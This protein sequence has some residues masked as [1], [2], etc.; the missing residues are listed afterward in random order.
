MTSVFAREYC[1]WLTFAIGVVVCVGILFIPGFLLLD[2][3]GCP[4]SLA[5]SLS[6][7]ISIL[8]CVVSGSLFG[9]IGI[10]VSWWA[11]VLPGVALGFVCLFLSKVSSSFQFQCES[12]TL[13]SKAISWKSLALFLCISLVVTFVVF[14]K[15]LD[16]PE[17][18]VQEFDNAYHLNL[19]QTFLNTGRFSTIQTALGADVPIQPLSEISYYPAAWHII[20]AL[21][22]DAVGASAAMAENI[23][24]AVFL[25]FVYPVSICAYLSVVFKTNRRVLICAAFLFMAFSAFPW[26]FLVAGPLYSNFAAMALFPA[27]MALLLVVVEMF[28]SHVAVVPG[29]V[30][31]AS[32]FSAALAQPNVL[33]TGAV[34]LAPYLYSHIARLFSGK[35]VWLACAGVALC[36]VFLWLLLRHFPILTSVVNNAWSPYVDNKFQAIFDYISLGFRNSVA[37]PELATLVFIGALY[38]LCARNWAVFLP[39]YI[40]FALAYFIVAMYGPDNLFGSLFSGYWYNDADR[41]AACGAMAALPLAS[42]GLYALS[43]F[44]TRVAE[45][46][47]EARNLSIAFVGVCIAATFLIYMPNHILP[48]RGEVRTALG[49]RRA[50]LSALATNVG[51]LSADER[52]FLEE[53]RAVV[54]DETVLNNPYDGSVFAY[55]CADIDIQF[56]TYRAVVGSPS[57]ID[58]WRVTRWINLIEDNEGVR[59]AANNLG[60]EYVLVLDSA[61]SDEPTMY[62]FFTYKEVQWQGIMNITDETPGFEVVLAEGDMRLYRIVD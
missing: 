40:Y 7:C 48:G 41:I 57:T 36:S 1:M 23:A 62:E 45:R 20:A 32:F 6:P 46:V 26:G 47:W 19:I 43:L 4:K 33:F 18:I 38:S 37:Q 5:I 42:Y 28:P 8:E 49:D 25:G 10:S 3:L 61:Q 29:L 39:P 31:C 56:K 14:L 24:N 11:V 2:A 9:L 58:S 35:R 15:P 27:A 13:S 52:S 12:W 16:G 50:R 53:C 51:A 22:A 59:E 30:S 44:V 21:S 34:L 60:I 54:G 55:A 17:S